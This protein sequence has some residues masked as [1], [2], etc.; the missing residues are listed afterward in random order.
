MLAHRPARRQR[1]RHRSGRRSRSRYAYPRSGRESNRPFDRLGGRQIACLDEHPADR[2]RGGQPR[3]RDHEE[4]AARR[5]QEVRRGL[6]RRQR[7]E[8][9]RGLRRHQGGLRRDPRHGGGL[10]HLRQPHLGQEGD[11]GGH[12]PHPPAPPA[13]QLPRAP[14]RPRL[15]R[16]QG[17]ALEGARRHAEP[18]RPRVHERG[19][20][21]PVRPR[22]EGDRAPARG[23]EG[24]PRG[25]ARR[26]ELG[27]DRDRELLRRPG[28]RGGRHPH[29]RAHLRPPAS[30]PGARPTAP[31][32]A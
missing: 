23:G 19:D 13:A 2:G 1:V 5:L 32:S 11:H 3:A 6:L 31:T 4:G 16:R 8:R 28:E 12:R 15:A 18:E 25:H 20:G 22:P 7:G 26:G 29:P 14:A 17:Q 10:P 30:C 27:E 21:R 9:G 24:H